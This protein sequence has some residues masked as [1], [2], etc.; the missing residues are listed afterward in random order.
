MGTLAAIG[1]KI[2]LA[3]ALAVGAAVAARHLQHSRGGWRSSTRSLRV[4]E[5]A[6]LG[7][8]RA[9][10][11][12]A[13]GGRTLL[14][15]STQGQVALLAD[16]SGDQHDAVAQPAPAAPSFAAVISRVLSLSEPPPGQAAHLH[17]A[18][19]KLRTAVSE[20]GQ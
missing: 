2:A 11:L 20:A 7:Q 14:I 15:A 4:L 13:V 8:Q 17:A 1:G 9:V 5:T 6:V 12:I 10:H 19:Q 18:A 3:A 16:V